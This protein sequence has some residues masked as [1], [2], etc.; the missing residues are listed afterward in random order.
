MGL[1]MLYKSQFIQESRKHYSFN[2][3][4]KWNSLYDTVV[5]TSGVNN[6][7]R[8][9]NRHWGIVRIRWA[10]P[11]LGLKLVVGHLIFLWVYGSK[12][13]VS[14]SKKYMKQKVVKVMELFIKYKN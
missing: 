6:F 4:I 11:T 3:L 10:E 2:S 8:Q 7:K 14:E 1:L 9:L 12:L 5:N 13:Q